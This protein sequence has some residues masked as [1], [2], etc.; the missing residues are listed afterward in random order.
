VTDPLRFPDP[1]EA[2][3]ELL[4]AL[5]PPPVTVGVGVPSKWDRSTSPTHLQVAWDGTFTAASRL[6]AT[7]TIRVCAWAGSTGAAKDAALDAHARL[8]AHRSGSGVGVIRPGVG[9]LPARD[10]ATGAQL[11]W[12]TVQ[13]TVRSTPLT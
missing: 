7:A 11:A 6:I 12:F 10:Q 13:A 8:C 1:E 3:K 4:K 2:V 9:P 5:T